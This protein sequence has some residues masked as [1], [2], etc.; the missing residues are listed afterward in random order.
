MND[1][2]GTLC[3]KRKKGGIDVIPPIKYEFSW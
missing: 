3:V 2:E 1:G